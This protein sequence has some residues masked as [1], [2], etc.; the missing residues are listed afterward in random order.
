[1]QVKTITNLLI[2]YDGKKINNI[3]SFLCTGK[4]KMDVDNFLQKEKKKKEAQVI[5][6]IGR[7][8]EKNKD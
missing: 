7:N 6:T 2:N 4:T 1:M 5:S 3:L 8:K